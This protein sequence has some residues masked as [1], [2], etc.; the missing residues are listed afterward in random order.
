MANPI[1]IHCHEDILP[2]ERAPIHGGPLHR[3]C[4]IRIIVGSIGHQCKLCHCYGGEVEDPP[5]FT[6]REAARLAMDY[7]VE[8]EWR[9][10]EKEEP[11]V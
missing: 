11:H 4:A 9:K 2:Q 3:E 5:G 7:H 6:L 8:V 10:W 1:C